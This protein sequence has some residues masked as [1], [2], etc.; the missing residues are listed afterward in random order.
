MGKRK[1][2]SEHGRKG[3]RTWAMI[4]NSPG[5]PYGDSCPVTK[6][7]LFGLYRRHRSLLEVAKYVSACGK[8]TH[9]SISR[10]LKKRGWLELEPRGRNDR[11]GYVPSEPSYEV[12]FGKKDGMEA[13]W[14]ADYKEG[15][16]EGPYVNEETAALRLMEKAGVKSLRTQTPHSERTVTP[17]KRRGRPP[18]TKNKP[19]GDDNAV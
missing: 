3:R 8:C 12:V 19:Q 4:E 11:P 10:W 5:K 6:D 9:V 15:V 16:S 1:K 13:F 2:I 18:G 7:V 14:L 17:G